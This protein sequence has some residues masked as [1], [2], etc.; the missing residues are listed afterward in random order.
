MCSADNSIK[1][2]E[3]EER[4]SSSSR[5][6]T[7]RGAKA[8][9][10]VPQPL[11][12][13]ERVPRKQQP[14]VEDDNDDILMSL[15]AMFDGM[16]N[17]E[18]DDDSDS[19]SDSS[20]PESPRSRGAVP[21][22]SKT[23][24]LHGKDQY[25]YDQDHNVFLLVGQSARQIHEGRSFLTLDNLLELEY[26][27]G[28]PY[29]FGVDGGLYYMAQDITYQVPTR[30]YY[31]YGQSFEP[32]PST[33]SPNIFQSDLGLP[34]DFSSGFTSDFNSDFNLHDNSQYPVSNGGYCIDTI[35]NTDPLQASLQGQPP[36]TWSPSTGSASSPIVS[37]TSRASSSEPSEP[38]IPNWLDP[39]KEETKKIQEERNYVSNKLDRRRCRHCNKVFRRPSSL[40]DHL[41][42]HSGSKPHICPFERCNTGFA[43]KSNMK[44]HFITH[45]VGKLEEYNRRGKLGEGRALT[46]TYNAKAFHTQRFRLVPGSA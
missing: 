4:L 16:W 25:Y 15:C 7:P 12:P 24:F 22:F 43:T 2:E 1:K 9:Q 39:W 46:A 35:V 3:V 29:Y 5:C 13:S 28:L 18:T 21:V 19:E 26:I 30:T 17:S 41:N 36:I 37:S 11:A 45:R 33:A 34:S 27:S 20:E 10:E 31:E 6:A 8:K 40:E 32:T 44:R 42:V 23:Y 38:L 14:K